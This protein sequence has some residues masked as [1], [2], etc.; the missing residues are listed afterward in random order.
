[1]EADGEPRW[2]VSRSPC[3]HTRLG[4]GVR[5][6]RT[7]PCP[8]KTPVTMPEHFNDIAI[9][10]LRSH[11]NAAP[12]RKQGPPTGSIHGD[13]NPKFKR[14][15]TQYHPSPTGPH[16][17]T[18]PSK[19]HPWSITWVGSWRPWQSRAC[20]EPV[21]R[22]M[23]GRAKKLPSPMSAAQDGTLIFS[24]I[25]VRNECFPRLGVVK[26]SMQ[27]AC[28]VLGAKNVSAAGAGQRADE[29]EPF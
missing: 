22:S 10:R 29:P 4:N 25:D 12:P 27:P 17:S 15:P 26:A 9:A 24:S 11:P 2:G 28:L 16:R 20:A 8:S 7:T 23:Y 3:D 21:S 6:S 5:R 1:M 14:G 19:R 18:P 13:G